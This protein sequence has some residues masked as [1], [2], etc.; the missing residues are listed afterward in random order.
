[1]TTRGA[2]LTLKSLISGAAFAGIRRGLRLPPTYQLNAFRQHSRTIDEIRSR[3]INVVFDVGANRG[4]YAKHL[5]DLGFD[6]YLLCFEPVKECFD[7]LSA[8]MAGDP[9]C[10]VFNCALGDVPGELEFNV[11][12]AADGEAVL[13][14]FLS[15]KMDIATDKRTVPVRTVDE[16]LRTELRIT[17]P[18]VFLKMDTQG[19][20]LKVFAGARNAPEIKLMLSE[21]AAFALY[22]EMPHYTE[23]LLQYEN[24][25]FELLDIFVL[26]Q[27]ETGAIGEFDVLL[28]RRELR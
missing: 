13:S 28:G 12:R 11:I 7:E 10:N 4:F 19:Y 6:G 2:A 27:T 16:V 26:G 5:R 17:S 9:N 8:R 1:M 3:D 23:V 24:S 18:R 14:S 25:G 20:D 15:P 21:V 22:D